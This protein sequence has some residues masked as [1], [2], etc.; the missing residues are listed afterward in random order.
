MPRQ[1]KAFSACRDETW[2]H[3][4]QCPPEANEPEVTPLP[5]GE[6]FAREPTGQPRDAL[7][8]REKHQ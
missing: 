6:E 4:E 1:A 3:L 7:Q 5:D 8:P 2:A